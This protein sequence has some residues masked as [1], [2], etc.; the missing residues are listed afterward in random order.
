VSHSGISVKKTEGEKLYSITEGWISALYLLMLMP[1]N[2]NKDK[3]IMIQGM[4]REETSLPGHPFL[5]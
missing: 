5:L 4:T 3:G 2:L 1:K